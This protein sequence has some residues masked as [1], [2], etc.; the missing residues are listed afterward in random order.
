MSYD[1]QKER[2]GLFTEDGVRMLV[3]M[4]DR[5]KYL[6]TESGAAR[7]Q[8][9]MAKSSGSSWQ[10]MACIDYLVETGELREVTQHS[11][12]WGQHR[13]FVDAKS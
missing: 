7:A 6:I 12:V 10:M 4:R 2:P 1:Y 5:A 3:G 8:E 9:I 13:V 11:H